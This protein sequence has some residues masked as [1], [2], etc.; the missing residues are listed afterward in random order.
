MTPAALASAASS[1]VGVDAVAVEPHAD[2]PCARRADRVGVQAIADIGRGRDR[3]RATEAVERLVEDARVGLRDADLAGGDD[4]LD[5]AVEREPHDLGRLEL[6]LAVRHDAEPHAG[7][8]LR[9]R[10]ERG[11]GRRRGGSTSRGSARST[12]RTT[13]WPTDRRAR[14]RTRGRTPPPVPGAGPR[15]RARRRG[16]RGS[17]PPRGRATGGLPPSSSPSY[18]RSPHV[19]HD[20]GGDRLAVRHEGVVEVEQHHRR[21]GR[22]AR[23]GSCRSPTRRHH[24]SRVGRSRRGR[25]PSR[26]HPLGAL[27]GLARRRS[28]AGGR[29]RP[30]PRAA[31]AC[32]RGSA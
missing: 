22:V 10:V 15:T 9:Q 27:A 30:G 31:R 2:Q 32:G 29:A 20:A 24:V 12:R 4:L 16:R 5:P 21:R 18:A 8:G 19:Q 1:S 13:R 28:R 25:R 17:A 26:E 14:R 6:E 11:R 7:Q 3:S 23:R